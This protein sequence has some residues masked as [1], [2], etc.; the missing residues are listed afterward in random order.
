MVTKTKTINYIALIK[1]LAGKIV[2]E[3]T[4]NEWDVKP[5]YTIP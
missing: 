2:F 4:Y 5:Y 3:M 1:Q